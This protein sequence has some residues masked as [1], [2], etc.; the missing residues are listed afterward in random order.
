[1]S[2]L[3]IDS[4][5]QFLYIILHANGLFQEIKSNQSNGWH[6]DREMAVR[7]HKMNR[8]NHNNLDSDIRQALCVYYILFELICMLYLDLDSFE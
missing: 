3:C 8:N 5:R 7:V 4:I 2:T 6:N 1:M